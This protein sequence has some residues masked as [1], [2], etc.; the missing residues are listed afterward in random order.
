MLMDDSM[1][2]V[3]GFRFF[4]T[5]ASTVTSVH[6]GLAVLDAGRKAVGTNC[7]SRRLRMGEIRLHP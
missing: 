6:G 3:E 4:L 5:V 7:G 1:W 2:F